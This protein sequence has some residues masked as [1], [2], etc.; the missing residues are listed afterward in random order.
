M[1][2]SRKYLVKK[3]CNLSSLQSTEVHVLCMSIQRC[4]S[5][6]YRK[7]SL[8]IKHKGFWYSGKVLQ[9]ERCRPTDSRF[10]LLVFTDAPTNI[11]VTN[12][13]VTKVTHYVFNL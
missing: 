12:N 4:R 5:K 6:Y 7:I 9:P 13:K 11:N 8:V 10:Q 3:P 2:F 1:D